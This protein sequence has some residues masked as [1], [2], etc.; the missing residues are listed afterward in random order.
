MF[1][2]AIGY[3]MN[4]ANIVL[5]LFGLFDRK[6]KTTISVDFLYK[7]FKIEE[8]TVVI[9]ELKILFE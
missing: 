9:F 3:V 1:G 4:R 5:M 7:Y 2:D 6:T 8:S